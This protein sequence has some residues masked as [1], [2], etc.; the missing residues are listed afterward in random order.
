MP[1]TREIYDKAQEIIDKRKKDAED[2]VSAKTRLFE[3]ME[4]QYTEY[5]NEMI[6]SVK[7]VV[8]VIDMSPEK[9]PEFIQ[10]QKIRNLTAQQN[11]ILLLRKNNLP[12]DYLETKYFCPVCEDTGFNESRLCSCHI[13]VLKKLAFDEEGKKSPLKF[14]RFEDFDLK[15]YPDEYSSVLKCSPREKMREILSFCKEYASSF[16][17]DNQ[18]LFMHGETGLGKTHLSLAIAG[19]AIEKGY[20]VIYNS[21]QNIFNELHKERFGKS[22]SNGAFEA[23]VL[24][25]DLLV[26]DDLGTEFQTQFTNSVLYNIINTRINTGL[27]TIISTNLTLSE[28]E[29]IYSKKISSRIIGEYAILT[30]KGNDIRQLRNETEN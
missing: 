23:M 20:S 29:N 18:S 21:A 7:E 22:D 13:E 4:P 16:E 2:K 3:A 10:K 12:D 14:C 19:K 24:E 9:A 8:K 28:I 26:I 30:F 15:Y 5:K 17:P 6:N 25:C 1:Y 27:P 11:I